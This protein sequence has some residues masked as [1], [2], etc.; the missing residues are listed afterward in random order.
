MHKYLAQPIVTAEDRMMHAIHL[1]YAVLK[2][3]TSSLCYY[4]LAP[5]EA[6]REIFENWR[7]VEASPTVHPTELPKP[8]KPIVPLPKSSLLRYPAPTSKGDHG[9]GRVTTS[10]VALK[11]QKTVISKER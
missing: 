5:I 11:Q 10:K 2:Y 8:P 7:T 3:V 1:L 4:Q 9:N 6:V